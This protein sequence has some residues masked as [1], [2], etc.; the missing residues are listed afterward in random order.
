[1]ARLPWF[2][3][4]IRYLVGTA[5]GAIL[6]DKVFLEDAFTRNFRALTAAAQTVIDYKI[7]FDPDPDKVAEMHTRVAN[8]ILRVC[9]KNG[10][11]YIKLGQ[12]IAAMNHV[13]PPQ[14]NE[15]LSLLYDRAPSVPYS[16]VEK[17]F[18]QDFG[19]RPEEIFSKFEKEPIAS[20]SIAQVH[21]AVLKDGTRV[22]VKV[23]KPYIRTQMPLD[24]LNYRVLVFGFEKVFDLPMYWTV[25]FTQQNLEKEADF[26]NE[27]NNTELCAQNIP[28]NMR[29]DL[30]VPKV[31]WDFSSSRVLTS[32]WID[33][34]RLNDMKS[35]E[36]Q[37]FKMPDL[38][39]KMVKAIAHQIFITGHVH[40]DPHP[41]NILV[42]RF[43]GKPQLV[44]LDHGLYLT[45][46]EKF[47][48]EYCDLWKAI[49]LLDQRKLAEISTKWGIKDHEMFASAQLM[50]PFD[51]NKAVH[52]QNT[53]KKDLL[54]FQMAAKEKVKEL[55]TDSSL[56][57]LELIFIGRS[58]NL[59]RANNKMAGSP[60]NRVSIL[61]EYASIGSKMNSESIRKSLQ[62]Y[63]NANFAK[64]MIFS[65]QDSI[66]ETVESISFQS[67]LMLI[68]LAFQVSQWWRAINSLFGRKTLNLEDALEY[69]MEKTMKEFGFQYNVDE[70]GMH[71]AG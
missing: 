17:I 44:L 63:N 1:M 9:Q 25:N 60:V 42:R 39:T 22:A 48:Q 53:S 46:S 27:G 6:Y 30:Y 51:P 20:A 31:H 8:R 34:T 16:R 5:A 15:V 64:K 24:L 55:L 38:I 37:G 45:E 35:L 62:R 47:R 18:M 11:L 54:K 52:L 10:G 66:K 29:Q 56:I 61:A 32:E 67:R 26:I 2:G 21:R 41:G 58:L 28:R 50:K 4:T 49:V 65:V 23:Q 40:A 14:Y 57:P 3:S 59:V 71:N 68:S 69:E 70:N 19:K 12:G 43:N 13:L 36:K 33:G 7:R